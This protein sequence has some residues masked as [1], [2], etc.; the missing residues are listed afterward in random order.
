MLIWEKRRPFTPDEEDLAWLCVIT[1]T[2]HFYSDNFIPGWS[3]SNWQSSHTHNSPWDS[4][5]I[6][7]YA[8]GHNKSFSW[9]DPTT[10]A[11]GS[12][13]VFRQLDVLPYM[14][15][16]SSKNKFFDANDKVG[17]NSWYRK[18]AI[19]RFPGNLILSRFC[20]FATNFLL[21]RTGNFLK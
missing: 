14:T 5:K 15:L 18:I 19:F 6:E 20:K 8:T 16:G 7:P 1:I 11:L 3:E 21:S 2:V 10:H 12:F 4:K 17:D 9:S 13:Y